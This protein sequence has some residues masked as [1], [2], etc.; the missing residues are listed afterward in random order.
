[1]TSLRAVDSRRGESISA[2]SLQEPV[3]FGYCVADFVAIDPRFP[4]GEWVLNGKCVINFT[5]FC[6]ED[7]SNSCPV[8]AK[9]IQLGHICVA[10]IP[11]DKS[12]R[13]T[14]DQ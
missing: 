1:M 4:K 7:K 9:V 10:N 14:F 2:D 5:N 12:R 13:C 8:G 3:A 11:I 6:V